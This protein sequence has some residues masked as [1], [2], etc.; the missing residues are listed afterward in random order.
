MSHKVAKYIGITAFFLLVLISGLG[1]W[2]FYSEND[3]N[4]PYLNSGVQVSPV[5]DISD[6]GKARMLIEKTKRYQLD[7][8]VGAKEWESLVPKNGGIIYQRNPETGEQE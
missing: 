1:L 6:L 3:L 4:V 7:T 8:E 2:H 5:W